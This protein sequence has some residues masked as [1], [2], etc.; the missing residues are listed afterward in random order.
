[1]LGRKLQGWLTGTVDRLSQELFNATVNKD[2][3][4]TLMQWEI[5]GEETA[6]TIK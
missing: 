2:C 5:V 3:K 1:M 4:K 6:R